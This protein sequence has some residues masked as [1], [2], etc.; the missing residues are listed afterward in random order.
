MSAPAQFMS[1]APLARVEHSH[2]R[3]AAVGATASS[4]STST[5]SMLD[6]VAGS[7]S[8]QSSMSCAEQQGLVLGLTAIGGLAAGFLSG[9]VLWGLVGAVAG[10]FVGRKINGGTPTT[11]ATCLSLDAR[12][13]L[14]SRILSGEV[15]QADAEKMAQSYELS[16]CAEDAAAIRVA[17]KTAASGDLIPHSPTPGAH[18]GGG[19]IG[20]KEPT[21]G[22]NLYAL[23]A[24][25]VALKPTAFALRAGYTSVSAFLAN[26]GGK[27]S[28]QNAPDPTTDPAVLTD[29]SV[30]AEPSPLNPALMLYHRVV[31]WKAG[32][33]V[34]TLVPIAVVSTGSLIN[35]AVATALG[36]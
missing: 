14:V 19:D 15:S 20:T 4:S 25:D 12:S 13:T 2:V 24:A 1:F 33:L 35:P 7:C 18:P 16:G 36:G 23:T 3:L 6:V 31:P 27:I 21:L 8:G 9:S 22:G 5:T 30:Y 34:V 26:Q 11:G 17:A 32:L 28:A 29:P 10:N